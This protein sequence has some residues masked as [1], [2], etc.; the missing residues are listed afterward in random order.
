MGQLIA[1]RYRTSMMAYLA[2]HTYVECG[3]G[4]AWGCFGGTQNG[5]A[6]NAGEGS[7]AR[8][9]E[10][11]EP[12]GKAGVGRYLIDG[13]CHQAA[14]RILLPANRL[15]T[16]AR[17]YWLSVAIFGTY[18]RSGFNMHP[19]VT[20]DL[21]ECTAA[22]SG[23]DISPRSKAESP[24]DLKY[25]RSNRSSV[26][27]FSHEFS[28]PV[29]RASFNVK[30]FMKDVQLTLENVSPSSSLEGLELAK[31]TS[32]MFLESRS[33]DFQNT[34]RNAAEFVR[35]F[36]KMTDKFQDDAAEALSTDDYER[37]FRLHPSERIRL[38]DPD[39]VNMAFGQGVFTA[40][41]SKPPQ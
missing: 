40:A 18:G 14:N 17:G 8:A 10:I 9:N 35:E 23:I 12:N 38:T 11:A 5:Q 37:L 1:K 27:Q 6:I 32:E 20:G 13:V 3:A 31:S 24:E 29:R 22:K 25:I 21:P 19:N 28:T 30:R 4:K 15:V 2:D 39:A 7:T 16:N 33:I 26:A 34:N 36:D 41:A